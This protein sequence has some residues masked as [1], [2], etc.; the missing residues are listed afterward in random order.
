MV[1]GLEE[2]IYISMEVKHSVLPQSQESSSMTHG[3]KALLNHFLSKYVSF[4]YFFLVSKHKIAIW[5][6]LDKKHLITH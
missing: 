5:F 1:V 2:Y 4:K 3:Q 6:L